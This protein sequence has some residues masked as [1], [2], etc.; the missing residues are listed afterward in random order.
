MIAQGLQKTLFERI[1]DEGGILNFHN[2][3]GSKEQ[4]MKKLFNDLEIFGE[5][6]PK[7]RGEAARVIRYWYECYCNNMYD[8]LYFKYRVSPKLNS[9]RVSPKKASAPT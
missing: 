5:R 1:E 3:N 6:G 9:A 8:K 4:K 7:K 2:S